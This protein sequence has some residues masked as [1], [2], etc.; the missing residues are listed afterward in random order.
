LIILITC[1][2]QITM[3]NQSV[4]FSELTDKS[5]FL[6]AYLNT[7][8]NLS[9]E[10]NRTCA[11]ACFWSCAFCFR[12]AFLFIFIN[13]QTNNVSESGEHYASSCQLYGWITMGIQKSIHYNR[14][15][16]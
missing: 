2:Y 15:S 7:C 9:I 6:P 1:I 11:I 5:T 8:F 13:F 4:N 16:N 10:K 3:M 14:V 12:F